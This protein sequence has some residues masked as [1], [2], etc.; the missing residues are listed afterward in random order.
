MMHNINLFKLLRFIKKK[1]LN[2]PDIIIVKK[3]SIFVEKETMD[4]AY[5]KTKE[6]IYVLLQDLE[7][8]Y[9]QNYLDK[10]SE[11]LTPLCLKLEI[12]ESYQITT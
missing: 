9:N 2:E 4:A 12:F 5:L 6:H 8:A 1:Y 11:K 10:K 3:D 7:S